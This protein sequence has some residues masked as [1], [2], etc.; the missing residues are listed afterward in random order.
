MPETRYHPVR[1]YLPPLLLFLFYLSAC[2]F[3]FILHEKR[4]VDE[5]VILDLR[6][7]VE[8]Q[9]SHFRSV[10]NSRF[11]TL[12]SLARFAAQQEALTSPDSLSMADA[13]VSTGA[14]SRVLIAAPS[15]MGQ[16]SDGEVIDVGERSYFVTALSGLRALSD[17]LPSEDGKTKDAAVLPDQVGPGGQRHFRLPSVP[18]TQGRLALER[19]W[20]MLSTWSPIRSKSVSISENR[21]QPSSEQIPRRMRSIWWRRKL[22]VMSSIFCSMAETSLS[23]STGSVTA[24]LR[25]SMALR[26]TA[27]ISRI[28]A[29][30][31]SEKWMSFSFRMPL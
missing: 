16:T 1:R 3:I 13:M 10:I 20:A 24:P 28:S 27:S 14:F 9:C 5:R 31:S 6:G 15:G 26:Q 30:A 19:S 7:N 23:H 17:P 18:P 4:V 2:I 21:M 11:S 12:D 8:Q 25:D 22:A 29:R